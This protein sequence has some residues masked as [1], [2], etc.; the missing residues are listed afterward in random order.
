M[1]LLPDARIAQVLGM[2]VALRAIA[3]HCDLFR[4]DQVQVGIGVVIDF[5]VFPLFPFIRHPRE[6][7]GQS[8]LAQAGFPLSRE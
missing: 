5:H 6:S 4:L 8:G 2:C 7:E 1:S 3:E